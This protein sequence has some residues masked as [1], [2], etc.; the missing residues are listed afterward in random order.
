MW[1]Q[2]LTAM[3]CT[4]TENNE[5]K[6]LFQNEADIKVHT[7]DCI[8]HHYTGIVIRIDWGIHRAVE[9]KQND[10]RMRG[11]LGIA[12]AIG[13]N[14]KVVSHRN[15]WSL[16][17]ARQILFLCNQYQLDFIRLSSINL[18]IKRDFKIIQFNN[19]FAIIRN[20]T[21]YSSI[22]LH[23]FYFSNQFYRKEFNY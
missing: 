20:D 9:Q 13:T 16:P 6:Y 10:N 21:N 19:V 2:R 14:V 8:T 5:R 3:E 22:Y 11:L 4:T 1:R 7:I 12:K 15:A 18:F 23:N 17:S